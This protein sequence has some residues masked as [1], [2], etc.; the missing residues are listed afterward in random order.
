MHNATAAAVELAPHD[1]NDAHRA[2]VSD[3]VSLIGHVQ[4]SLRLT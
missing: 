1:R 2:V 4:T 3:R